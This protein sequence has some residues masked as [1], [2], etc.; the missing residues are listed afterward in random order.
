MKNLVIDDTKEGLC[1]VIS[2]KVMYPKFEGQSKQSIKM[3]QVGSA[4][5]ALVR[6]EFK[7]FLERHPTFVKALADKLEKAYKGRQ[8]AK[9]ARDAARGMKSALDS[10]LPGKLSACSSKKPEECSLYIVEGDSA[11]GSAIQGRDSRTQAILPVF[12]K[13]LNTE[14]SRLED[15]ISNGKLLDVVKAL[16]CGIGK[17]FDI[18]KLRYHKIVIMADADVD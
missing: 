2:V 5:S 6:D 7:F 13:V 10:S 12:G 14:K 17:D 15:A 18:K 4:V 11:A 9:R 16:K 3:P 1:A 8:A